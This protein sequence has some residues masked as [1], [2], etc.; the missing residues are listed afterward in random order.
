MYKYVNKIFGKHKLLLFLTVLSSFFL[1][2]DG[3]V[4]PHF[5]GRF[6]DT[7]SAGAFQTT[8]K[9]LIYWLLSLF[10]IIMAQ[11]AHKFFAQ[12]LIQRI[13]LDLK[14]NIAVSSLYQNNIQKS[15]SEYLSMITS[16]FSKIEEKFI[17]N[18]FTLFLCVFQGT[19][20]FIYLM[21][22][23]VSVGLVF[24]GL[25][26]LPA[27][28][29][30]LTA[31][32]VKKGTKD[33]QTTNNLYLAS[34]EDFLLGRKLMI[35]FDAEEFLLKKIEE[36]LNDNEKSYFNMELIQTIANSVV[37]VLYI[38]GLIISLMIGV[39]EVVNGNLTTGQLITIYMAG[40]RVVSPLISAVSIYNVL[41]STEPILEKVFSQEEYVP[42]YELEEASLPHDTDMVIQKLYVGYD[43]TPLIEDINLQIYTGE[44][45]LITADSGAGK[46]SFIRTLMLD[47]PPISGDIIVNEHLNDTN[48]QKLFGLVE[49]S[50]FIFNETLLFNLTFGHQID[51]SL[52]IDSLNRVGLEKFANSEQLHRVL[53]KDHNRLS[54]GELKRIEIARSILFQKPILLIDEALS[55]LDEENANR[56]NQLIIDY[57]G[58]VL[59]IEHHFSDEMRER[60]T[61]VLNIENKVLSP[62]NFK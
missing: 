11:T 17:R 38:A 2:F 21:T 10:G 55:G 25:G 41:Q 52:V 54:G 9:I 43:D 50:P 44:K 32:W 7:M 15:S 31:N 8:Y 45:I 29:P 16:E 49:Q 61:L 6:T 1:S 5:L 19:I 13:G 3:L 58:T 30:R 20:T 4:S 60:Y 22:I 53:N 36:K 34:L 39:R 42:P 35:R 56:L 47:I 40:D 12:K 24:V 48:P 26:I 27:I 33:W 37:S 18:I 59:D 62:K 51:E 23:N 28:V 57:P 14:T 46:S